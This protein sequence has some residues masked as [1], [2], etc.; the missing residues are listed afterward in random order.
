MSHYTDYLM[1]FGWGKFE[2]SKN[3]K[4]TVR[5]PTIHPVVR[6]KL[7]EQYTPVD[8]Q[9]RIRGLAASTKMRKKEIADVKYKN[10]VFTRVK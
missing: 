1:P 6:L 8:Q 3:D 2:D 5:R 10:G 9:D 4:P 7:Y